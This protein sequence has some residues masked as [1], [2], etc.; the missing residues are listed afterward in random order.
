MG[1]FKRLF[2]KEKGKEAV[3]VEEEKQEE[4]EM[5][6]TGIVCAACEL[7]IHGE[8]KSVKVAGKRYHVK[9]CWR[10]IQKMGKQQAFG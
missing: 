6:P 1:I 3:V 7:D 4:V 10:T 9:P 5:E 2:K 8:Q